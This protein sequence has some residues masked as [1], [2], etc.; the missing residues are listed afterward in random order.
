[1]KIAR[2]GM[3]QI[4]WTSVLD[5]AVCAALI[6]AALAVHPAF[7]AGL[8]VPAAAGVAVTA[9]FRDPERT[10]PDGSGLF[11]S[12]ADG[13][14]ADVTPL[15]ADGELG[16]EAVKI[17]VFMSLADVHVN[18]SPA[19]ARV[20][21]IEHRDGTY[22]D[23]RDPHASE[24]NEA[25]TIRM[26]CRDAAGE[27]SIIVRQIAGLVARR[28]VTDLS[29]GQTVARGQRIGMIKFGSRLE[30]IVPRTRARRV[31]VSVGD[32]VT[33]GETVLIADGEAD[34]E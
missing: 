15:G 21:R 17:G 7:W 16:C 25:A 23:A 20:E 30:L 8:I 13:R 19:D 27:F 5:A 18:R 34:H 1:M 29:E 11:V 4:L 22:L 6:W 24:R 2:Y 33:A 26:T 31:Q 28:I 14:V 3:R 9:F 10:P 12:P 32:R